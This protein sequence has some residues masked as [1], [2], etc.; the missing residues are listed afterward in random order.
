M[1]DELPKEKT[2]KEIAENLKKRDQ[3]RQKKAKI[4]TRFTLTMPLEMMQS[5]RKDVKRR[6]DMTISQWIRNA[7]WEKIN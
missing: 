1:S 3:E 7:I 4:Y 2:F 5:I 6:S